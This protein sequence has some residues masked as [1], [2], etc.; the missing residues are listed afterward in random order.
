MFNEARTLLV[1]LPGSGTVFS[2]IPADELIPADYQVVEFPSYLQSI[3]SR[4]FGSSPDRAMLNYRVAQLLAMINSTELQ[5]Y[6]LELDPRLTYGNQ[7]LVSDPAFRP[8]V[9]QSNGEEYPS[10]G[11][12]SLQGVEVAPDST[13]L[14]RYDYQ[15][16]ADTGV[17]QEVTVTTL[18]PSTVIAPRSEEVT[19]T[20]DMSNSFELPGSG[21]SITFY[22]LSGGRITDN[23]TW[24]VSGFK[25]PTSNLATTEATLRSVGEPALLQLFG[26]SPV[27]PFLTFKNCWD[28]HPDF[29]YRLGGIILAL[30]YRTR[31]LLDV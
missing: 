13:G 28:S 2:D 10:T 20:S 14:C 1:N 26:P 24:R 15:V 18:T 25:R 23:A 22:G 31:G 6:V 30:V 5:Q 3:R 9:Y 12:V 17:P 11:Q 7:F 16:T 21:Y 8:T 19:V 27:E 29:S 4:I